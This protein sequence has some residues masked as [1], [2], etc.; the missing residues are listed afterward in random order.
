VIPIFAGTAPSVVRF[1]QLWRSTNL[2]PHV[3]GRLYPDISWKWAIVS[4]TASRSLR[5][6]PFHPLWRVLL[7]SPRNFSR[8]KAFRARMHRHLPTRIPFPAT[9]APQPRGSFYAKVYRN[10]VPSLTRTA[11]RSA[12]SALPAFH[13]SC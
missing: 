5:K 13:H 1:S 7:S 11:V 4:V 2:L 9:L 10:P 6:Y 8:G 12:R 3:I